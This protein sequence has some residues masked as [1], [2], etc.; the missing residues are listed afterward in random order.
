[1]VKVVIF[2]NDSTVALCPHCNDIKVGSIVGPFF[3]GSKCGVP[4]KQIFQN[5]LLKS[6][7]NRKLLDEWSHSYIQYQSH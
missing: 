5:I 7:T 4:K 6:F 1:M 2:S 3:G